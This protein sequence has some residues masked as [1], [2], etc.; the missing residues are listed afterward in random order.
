MRQLGAG[1]TP[2]KRPQAD[3]WG[4]GPI[5]RNELFRLVFAM[6]ATPGRRRAMSPGG[7]GLAG[8]ATETKTAHPETDGL[9]LSCFQAS[10]FGEVTFDGKIRSDGTQPSKPVCDWS[11]GPWEGEVKDEFPAMMGCLQLDHG[12]TS[13]AGS[14]FSTSCGQ[15]IFTCGKQGPRDK[16][17]VLY[18]CF[19]LPARS[20][21][22]EV[23]HWFVSQRW[24]SG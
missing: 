4:S 24:L 6:N 9:L 7:G 12:Y 19:T 14:P 16:Y 18:Q 21:F 11:V 22:V 2:A 3:A 10:L 13:Y 20:R 23:R 15:K 8:K 17:V 5:L 1:P